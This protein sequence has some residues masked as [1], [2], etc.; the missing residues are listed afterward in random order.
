[1]ILFQTINF[2]GQDQQFTQFYAAPLYL[3]PA[4]AGS[5]I[6]SRVALNYRNQ[7]PGISGKF[8][9]YNA[10]Y[11]QY[12][13][14]IN[15][16]FGIMFSNDRS[17]TGILQNTNLALQYAYELHINREFS[18]RPAINFSFGTNKIDIDKLTFGDQLRN[19]DNSTTSDPDRGAYAASGNVYADFGAGTLLF[20][21]NLWLGI[22]T[23]HINEPNQSL[24]E[25][26]TP[27]PVKLSVHGGGRINISKFKNDL[28]KQ[29][30]LP[31]FNYRAQGKYDQL[32]LGFYYEYDPVTFGLWYR[33][34]PAIKK[35]DYGYLNHDD[36]A[37]LVGY[38]INQIKMGYSYDITISR[39]AANTVGSH[40]VSIII[41]WASIKSKKKTKRRVIPCAKF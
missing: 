15:S 13:S 32:D 1:V 39:L 38:Q 29:H 41:E 3:N 2:Y 21:E 11:D 28:R 17:G 30:I 24:L 31:C 40:E 37:L 16:G 20:S 8:I 36:V 4:F 9:S 33:G 5:S 6:Q 26:E 18:I 22:S 10:S 14:R 7:W 35:N 19:N 34:L 27:L 23:M 12:F 25:K